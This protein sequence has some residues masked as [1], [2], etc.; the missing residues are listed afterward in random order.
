MVRERKKKEREKREG[1]TRMNGFVSKRKFWG[2]EPAR[3]GT[4]GC[5]VEK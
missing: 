3:P 1:R 2:R 5:K 4:Q